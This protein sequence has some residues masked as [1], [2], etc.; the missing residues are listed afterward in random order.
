[1]SKRDVPASLEKEAASTFPWKPQS[2]PEAGVAAPLPR[3]PACLSPARCCSHCYS[4]AAGKLSLRKHSE[5]IWA[6]QELPRISLNSPIPDPPPHTID[7]QWQTR[8]R[9]Q[10]PPLALEEDLVFGTVDIPDLLLGTRLGRLDLHAL[11]FPLSAHAS[12]VP[13]FLQGALPHKHLLIVWGSASREPSS[14]HL[15][16]FRLSVH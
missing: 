3:S 12:S 2:L 9:M 1:M 14:I 10:K 7:S 6:P 13:W 15:T 4:F 5:V 8:A 16:H 11:S